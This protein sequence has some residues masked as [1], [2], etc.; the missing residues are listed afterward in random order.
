MGDEDDG[1][2]FLTFASV[3]SARGGI[4]HGSPHQALFA[5]IEC[6]QGIAP[7]D[8]GLSSGWLRQRAS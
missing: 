8:P 1:S 2:V 7:S 6:L 3:K 5:L 4:I